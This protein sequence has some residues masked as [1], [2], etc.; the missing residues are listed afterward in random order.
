MENEILISKLIDNV[1]EEKRPISA[2]IIEYG[3]YTNR[4]RVVFYN[5]REQHYDKP[6]VADTVKKTEVRSAKAFIAYI[7]DEL[8]R[9]NNEKGH[10]A[11]VQIGL[12]GGKFTADD[13]FNEGICTYSRLKSEQ[14]EA[15][16]SAK[17]ETFSQSGFL[18]LLQRL[19]PSIPD[20]KNIWTTFSKLRIERNS[21]MASNPVF[22]D[23]LEME[24][25]CI[26]TYEIQSGANTGTTE[27]VRIPLEFDVTM[28]FV[29][30]GENFYNF[31]VEL[32]VSKGNYGVEITTVIPDYERRIE[33]AI[34]DEA[35]FIKNELKESAEL[36]VL[37]DL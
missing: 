2:H 33:Q 17:N 4:E 7:K 22:D 6:Y 1:K 11:S 37:A 36:L 26:C 12:V 8:A 24:E 15:L 3:K 28:P 34:I 20:F 30:A 32:V 29:K 18:Q 35:E 25:G 27:E 13:N 14:L 19:K 21:R 31:K 9:R 5:D 23:N 16:E 10:H